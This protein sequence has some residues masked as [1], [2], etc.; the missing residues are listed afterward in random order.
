MLIL[1]RNLADKT[2]V[3]ELERIADVYN[4][5]PVPEDKVRQA[6]ADK[7]ESDGPFD[8]VTVGLCDWIRSRED[9]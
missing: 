7:V 1:G 5:L 4:L 3:E 2:A 9:W 6:I 8:A